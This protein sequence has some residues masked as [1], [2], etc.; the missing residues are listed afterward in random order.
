MCVPRRSCVVIAGVILAGLI[1]GVVCMALSQVPR[2]INYQGR[3]VDAA[4]APLVG[5]HTAIFRIFTDPT[6]GTALWTETQPVTADSAGV[7]AAVLGSVD[8]IGVAFD[9]P[10]WLEVEVDGEVLAPRREM[11]SVPF[12]IQAANSHAVAG[13]HADAFADSAHTHHSL[14]AADGN[15]AGVVYVDGSGNVGVA[16]QTPQ[17]QLDVAGTTRTSGFT[18]PTGAAVGRILTSDDGGTGTWQAPL[19]SPD[20]D[21]TISGDDMSSAVPGNI[22]I[23]TSAPAYKVHILN[24]SSVIS[25]HCLRGELSS[26]TAEGGVGLLGGTNSSASA[27]PSV[28]VVGVAWASTGKGIGVHGGSFAA[29]GR[30][31]EGL[32][33]NGSGVNYAIYGET[34]SPIGYAGYF[35]GGHNYF[36]GRVGIGTSGPM[37]PLQVEGFPFTPYPIAIV[38]ECLSDT[39]KNTTGVYGLVGSNSTDNPG[40]GVFGKA[41]G[42]TGASSGVR[43]QADGVTGR[44][45]WGYATHYSGA[46]YGVYGETGSD[47]GYAGYFKGGRNYFSGNVGIGTESPQS[48]LHLDGEAYG[49]TRLQMSNGSTG[50]T[51]G[52]G[53]QLAVAADGRGSLSNMEA[54]AL[55]FGTGGTTRLS[56]QPDGKISIGGQDTLATVTITGER[57]NLALNSTYSPANHASAGIGFYYDGAYES[58]I[59]WDAFHG[60]LSI[61]GVA[62][63]QI[64]DGRLGVGDIYPSNLLHVNGAGSTSG[65]VNGYAEVVGHFTNA[66][67]GHTAISVDALA[68]LDPILYLA[69]NG[70]AFWDMR[71]DSDDG[72]KF[73]LR[74]HG[75]AAK[76]NI[77]VVADTLGNVGVG[78]TAP[79]AKLDVSGPTGYAQV[80]MRTAFTPTGT[81]DTHGNVGDVAWDS[82][83]LYVKTAAG[84][85]RTAL[86]TW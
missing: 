9:G 53:L 82:N 38:G 18:M 67:S 64:G 39:A 12:A 31:I 46:N 66:G 8:S 51:S 49:A 80:R 23:G 50:K 28:G 1:L 57:P 85:K 52:D 44:G 78:T 45:V 35:K 86:G 34:S 25:R 83:Y 36:S 70:K 63:A 37:Y 6:G 68:G 4:G 43:G 27:T 2:K 14:D 71:T 41:F 61:G 77:L 81:A 22:G 74:Y 84:W 79:T 75:P 73:E 60:L 47:N 76:N 29:E 48:L 15:P 42:Q 59:T 26:P 72:Q 55:D 3:L 5:A 56:V 17:A 10:R 16:T 19:A 54:N 62:H 20:G 33:S 40:Q 65:G 7:F 30:G 32:A 11:A 13:L 58:G 69:E 24:S 21:W